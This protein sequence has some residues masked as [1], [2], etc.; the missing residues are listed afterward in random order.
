MGCDRGAAGLAGAAS[1]KQ[2]LQK[3]LGQ[4]LGGDVR[5]RG[6]IGIRVPT[7]GTPNAN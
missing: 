3:V 2:Q 7:L 4:V 5:R 1:P 6:G